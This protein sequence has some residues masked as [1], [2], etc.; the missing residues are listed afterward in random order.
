MHAIRAVIAN[1][2]VCNI[3]RNDTPADPAQSGE[4]HGQRFLFSE[5]SP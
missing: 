4:Q 5:K 3:L 2:L 1:K